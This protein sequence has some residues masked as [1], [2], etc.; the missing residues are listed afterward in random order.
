MALWSV[1]AALVYTVARYAPKWCLPLGH[2]TVA[3]IVYQRH[4]AWI[5]HE[6]HRPG[7]DGEP[8]IDIIFAIGLFWDA[9]SVCIALLPVTALG[10]YLRWRQ[11]RLAIRRSESAIGIS[12]L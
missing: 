10:I 4:M 11:A 12:F 7:W 6:M 1:F 8:D 3:I 2:L 5:E 9:A